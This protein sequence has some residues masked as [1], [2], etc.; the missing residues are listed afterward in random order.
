MT[1]RDDLEIEL[2]EWQAAGLEAGIWWRDDDLGAPSPGLDRLL[3]AAMDLSMAPLLAVVPKWATSDL[4]NRLAG[5]SVQIAVHGWAHVDHEAGRGKKSEFG[6]A[7]PTAD[8]LADVSAGMERLVDLFSDDPAFC[9]VPPWNRMIPELAHL[10]PSLGIRGLSLF[11]RH[12][13]RNQVPK[14][15]QINTHVDVI[16]WRGDR[17]FIGADAMAK[18]IAVELAGRRLERVGTDEPIGLLTHHLEMVADDWRGF[19]T[20]GDVLVTHPAARMLRSH[21]LFGRRDAP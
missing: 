10:L 11:G 13:N 9:F 16:N 1:G 15:D 2:A 19:E 6:S 8:L 17:R 7:R 21:D 14:L 12:P 3:R 4:P 5:H 20:V 18:A